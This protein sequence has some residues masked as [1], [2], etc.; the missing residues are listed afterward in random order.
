MN[1]ILKII[2]E[3]LSRIEMM[4]KVSGKNV[5][6]ISEAAVLT[7]LP[8]GHIYRLTSNRQIP[9][10]KRGRKLYFRRDEL[11]R[12]MLESKVQTQEEVQQLATTYIATHKSRI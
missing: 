8:V 10:Y 9:H 3:Q 5:L 12:W 7:S 1:E 4:T 6:D 2:T 11:E